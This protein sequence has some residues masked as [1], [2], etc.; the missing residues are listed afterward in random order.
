MRAKSHRK[1]KL[2]EKILNSTNSFLRGFSDA[3]LTFVSVTKVELSNDLS[4]AKVY[5]DTFDAQ[6]RDDIKK[7]II[8]AKGKIRTQL[9]SILEMRHVPEIELIYDSQYD[10]EKKITDILAEEAK[11]GK[12]SS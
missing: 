9:S 1:D 10:D 3:R 5:W 7:A 6:N 8:K 2:Q 4:T 12:I 11:S